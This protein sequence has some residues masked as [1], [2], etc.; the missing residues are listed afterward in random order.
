MASHGGMLVAQLPRRD[1][2]FW[3]KCVVA[4]LRHQIRWFVT[5]FL[6]AWIAVVPYASRAESL[7]CADIFSAAAT[8]EADGADARARSLIESR[9]ADLP[10]RA[11]GALALARFA[12]RYHLPARWMDVG[13]KER[14]VRRLFV[15]IDSTNQELV[16]AYLAEFNLD[17]RLSTNVA[18]TLALEFQ[19][20]V[21]GE[22]VTG[23]LR[24]G[25][26]PT[27]TIWRW[28]HP[29]LPR[30]EWFNGKM[31]A[32][33]DGINGFGHLIE[34]NDKELANV[35]VY[36]EH[37]NVDYDD[38]W[39]CKPKSNNCVAW[40]SG[41]ELG[42]TAVD[43][44]PAERRALFSELG[45][46]RTMAHFEI[47][48]RLIH[49]ANDRHTS[50]VV[51]Y[52]GERGLQTFNNGLESALPPEPKI[53]Y[54]Q[55]VRGVKIESP[56]AKA[57]DLL[58]DGAKIFIPIA[59][60]ASPE[61]ISALIDRATALDKGFDVHVLVNGISASELRRGVET[62]DG[63]FRVH[64][65]FLGSNLRDLAAEGK[66]DVIP[67]NLSDFNRMVRDP[68]QTAFHYDAIVVRVS[69]PDSLGHYSL[70]PNYDMI[71]SILKDRPG[72][73]VIAE[74]NR[75][76]PFTTGD[77]YITEDQITAHFESNAGLA[78]PAVVPPS[79]VDSA[80]GSNLAKLVDS[81]SYLQLGIGNIFSGLPDGMKNE[82]RK[83]VKIWTEMFGDPMMELI[84][85][86]I[87]TSAQTGFAYGSD[88]MYTWLDHNPKVIFRS[89][90][91]V[92]S[93]ARIQRLKRFIAINTALQVNL[94]GEVNATMGPNGRI[95]SPGGQVEFMSGAA[96]SEGGKAIIAIRSTA[97]NETLSSITLDL[98]RGPITTPHESVTHVVTE[99]GIA[100]LRGK[101]VADRAA[102]LIAIAHP[103][104]RPSLIAEAL[105]RKILTER[106]AARIPVQ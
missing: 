22:Y 97:R 54:M 72:I 100:D 51:F 91:V 43:A 33:P 66:V 50:V 71:M 81:N 94:Y 59:A 74:I 89:T 27:D 13:P 92:N 11:E 34:L 84:N 19:S 106:Q 88:R 45:M 73:K 64:P 3:E 69:K 5:F 82:G 99:F 55:V 21:V 25:A 9:E 58:P 40:I 15:G 101:G 70:G 41:I 83:N 39:V 29:D 75:N 48:R 61:A 57:V 47:G 10:A 14:R 30:D 26:K 53:P 62:T 38:P 20:E 24:P 28:G 65:L 102:A 103:K 76:I 23:V 85:M 96:R 46:A 8:D 60:G 12:A 1:C 77:N 90:E 2:Y 52:Q 67:G 32:K 80:I 95:S 87:A 42:R 7:T 36:L 93:P 68:Q 44:T 78:G 63:K 4:K 6:S 17:H 56:A 98:Y 104:F 37:A 16:N 31:P 35:R 18:G 86:G 79:A 105:N 49:A